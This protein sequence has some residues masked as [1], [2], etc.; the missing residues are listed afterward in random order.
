MP[1]RAAEFGP[2]LSLGFFIQP[3]GREFSPG[4]A[5]SSASRWRCRTCYGASASRSRHHRRSIRRFSGDDRRCAALCRRSLPDALFDHTAFARSRRRRTDRLRSVR[6][7]VQP[8]A[9]GVQQAAAA[10]KARPCARRRHR[11]R[12]VRTI[13]VRAVRRR[14]DR[15]FRLA[16]GADGIRFPDAP[17]RAAVAGHR[18]TCVDSSASM[19]LPRTSNRQD[20]AGGGVRPSLLRLL[21]LGFFTCGFQLAFITVHLPAYLADRGVS[22]R[23]AARS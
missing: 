21:V 18:D 9:V 4:A 7:F 22:R 2:R 8:G 19:G 12:L 16:G 1:D 23:P 14:D 5:T 20:R 13:P 17:D 15:Q 10:R 11:G 6:L 3:M